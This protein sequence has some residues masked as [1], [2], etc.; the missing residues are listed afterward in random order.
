MIDRTL[1]LWACTTL[2]VHPA[3]PG[4]CMAAATRTATADIS[5]LSPQSLSNVAWALALSAPS[6]LSD[7]DGQRTAFDRAMILGWIFVTVTLPYRRA[8]KQVG[9]C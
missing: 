8:V 3:L 6:V 5:E 2:R 7:S 4:L 9:G 1:R